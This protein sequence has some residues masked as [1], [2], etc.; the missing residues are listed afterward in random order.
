[1]AA[2][3]TTEQRAAY[4][5]WTAEQR[6]DYDGWPADV[7]AYYWTLTP[8]QQKAWWVL[9]PEQRT[10]VFGMTPADRTTTWASIEAQLAAP[11][12]VQTQANPPGPGPASPVPPNPETASAPVPPAMPADPGYM[13]GPYKGA[14]TPPPAAAMSKTYPL[15][16]RDVQ[17]SCVNPGEAGAG[18][19]RAARSIRKRS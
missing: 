6:S 2:A 1:M 15:C 5:A 7:S 12:V 14:L 4:D 9:K 19:R 11:N 17:D 18:Q 10:Q 16:T 8:A 13:A 3:M